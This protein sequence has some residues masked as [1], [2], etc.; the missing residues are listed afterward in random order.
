MGTHVP[1]ICQTA[2]RSLYAIK[3]LRSKGMDETSIYSVCQAT[4]VSRLLYA[5]PAWWGFANEGEKK[6][7]QSILNRATRWGF[8]PKN[9]PTLEAICSHR[10]SNLFFSVLSNPSHVLHQF[11]PPVKNSHHNLRKRA[12]NRELPLKSN[13]L[14]SKNFFSRLLYKTIS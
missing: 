3:L 4:V 2:A 11:L 1:T 14:V 8:Y 7:L 12:H 9:G 13:A 5:A 6:R 10:E